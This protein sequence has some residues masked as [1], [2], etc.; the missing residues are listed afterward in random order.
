MNRTM[1]DLCM[2]WSIM[3]ER[4]LVSTE[5]ES[6]TKEL[7]VVMRIE[8][9][10]GVQFGVADQVLTELEAVVVEAVLSS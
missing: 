6:G 9:A 1:N 5:L 3:E 8:I 4:Q 10:S 2:K 7:G